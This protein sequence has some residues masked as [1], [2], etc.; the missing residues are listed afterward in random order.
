LEEKM[1]DKNITSWNGFVE[2]ELDRMG[3]PKVGDA[4]IFINETIIEKYN[5]TKKVP[6]IQPEEPK[7]DS[8]YE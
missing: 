8:L 7:T 5:T 6:K 2:F 1:K 3:I 4:F